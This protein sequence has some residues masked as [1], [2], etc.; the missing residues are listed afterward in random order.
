VQQE[1]LQNGIKAARLDALSSPVV[2]RIHFRF[3]E[4]PLSIAQPQIGF[5]ELRRGL[6][7][8]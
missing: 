3:P 1:V 4:N 2:P 8:R 7:E 5:A 6:S